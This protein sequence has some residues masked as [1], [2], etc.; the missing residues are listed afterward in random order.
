MGFKRLVKKS[1]IGLVKRLFPEIEEINSIKAQ[2]YNRQLEIIQLMGT[3]QKLRHTDTPLPKFEDVGFRVYSQ[4]DEDGLLV[5]LFALIGTN[6]RT[7][8]DIG[9]GNPYG[10]NTT[11][12][13]VNMGWTGLLIDAGKNIETSRQFFASNRDTF[14]Y[15]P[16][17]VN[18]W[19]TAENINGIIEQNGFNGEVDLLSIDLDGVDYWI[20]KNLEVIKPRVVVVEYSN[21]WGPD[22]AVTVPYRPDFNRFDTHPDFCSASLAAYVKLGRQKGYRL[23]GCN[24]YGFNA[25]FV[26]NGIAEDI[27][28][29]T[30]LDKCLKH[31]Q[32]VEG[33]RDRLPKVITLG[34]VDV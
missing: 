7:C 25:F 5:Y 20:W 26:R 28:S 30:S 33:H 14:I 27:L 23:V 31:P 1:L 2:T 17:I 24:R 10:S 15:P 32:A 11:N 12:L 6:S 13:I 19:V 34:W 29:E 22:R 4:N 16:R 3:Y 21:F 9:G 18:C 8:I